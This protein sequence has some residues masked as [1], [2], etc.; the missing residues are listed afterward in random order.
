MKTTRKRLVLLE[1]YE[2]DLCGS[3]REVVLFRMIN[4]EPDKPGGVETNR[5][6]C[7]KCRARLLH[8]LDRHPRRKKPV[9][10]ES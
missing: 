4:M 10:N 6:L 8:R 2:C 1:V 7:A 3:T 5:E 9:E